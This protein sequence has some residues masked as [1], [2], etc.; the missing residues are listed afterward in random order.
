MTTVPIDIR[1]SAESDSA[2]L[3]RLYREAWRYAYRGII[4]GI[5]LEA[6]IA[7]RGTDWWRRA[8]RRNLRTLVLDFDG[9]T[10]GYVTFGR[11]RSADR[12]AEGE[13]YELYLNPEFHGAGF[14]RHLFRAAR[15][16]L[17]RRDLKR[18]IVWS[19]ADNPA[20]C[21]FYAAMGGRVHAKSA[22]EIGG[23]T[24]P[25]LGYVWW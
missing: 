6:M 23:V 24:L 10:A 1:K 20:A 7:R 3:A 21:R 9:M 25:M 17:V 11:C 15:E 12:L 14:G 4:P 16:E 5:A 13:I 18:L 2:D 8:Y 19:L 22:Q